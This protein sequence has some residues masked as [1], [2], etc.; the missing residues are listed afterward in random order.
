MSA[1]LRR[2]WQRRSLAA[3]LLLPLALLNGGLVRLRRRLYAARLL[4]SERLPVPVIVVGNV[5]AGGG[6][7][8]PVTRALV[9]HLQ[10]RGWRPGV[11]SRGYGR[12]DA[13]LR[14][15]R[16]D[17]DARAVGD[18]PLLLARATGAPVFVARR[19]AEAGR[20][21]LAAHPEVDV[22]VCDDGLQHLALARDLEICVFNDQGVGNGWL[23]PAGPLR[24]P[25]PRAVD[26]VLHAGAPPPG[27]LS[28]RFALQRRLADHAVDGQGRRVPLA[29]LAGRR[30]HALAGT[31]RP[32]E[33]FALLRAR[34]LAPAHC[35]A[36]PDHHGFADW[37]PPGDA[38]AVV[39]CTEKDAVKLWPRH[40]EV[41][42]VPLEVR[43]DPRF[44]QALDAR[45]ASLRS[46]HAP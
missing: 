42:A 43:L 22:L 45:L 33:F 46:P 21:L 24:E 29:H 19:R 44:F 15:V 7:K 34:G 18:E 2:L 30:L 36:F 13:Q 17:S 6:G 39:L 8:T 37:Q 27:A 31:A 9:A 40:P 5:V 11:I 10:A 26:W 16:P 3:A 41:L 38:A 20:A 4:R 25:W 14:A 1:R 23:L 28:A 12:A 35:Q 32:E